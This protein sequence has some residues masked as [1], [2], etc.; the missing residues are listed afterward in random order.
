MDERT[1]S[2]L[3]A[4]DAP[5]V[6]PGPSGVA[7]RTRIKGMSQRDEE[8]LWEA[9]TLLGRLAA[10][11][12]KA[13]CRYGTGHDKHA[14]A[15]RKRALT[16]LSS[17]RWAG[18]I[19]KASNDQWALSRRN[20]AAFIAERRAAVAT[21]SH[22]LSLPVGEPG[23]KDKPGGYRSKHEYFVKSRRLGMLEGQLAQAQ[24]D[25]DAGRVHVCR[26]GRR[27][28]NNRHH[29]LDDL[30][31]PDTPGLSPEELTAE[32]GH[33]VGQWRTRWNAKRLFLHAD[34][35]TG[36]RWGNLTIRLTPEGEVSLKLPAA[37]AHRANAPHG[38]Y[39]LDGR[40]TF[41][42]RGAEW[43]DR[44]HADRAVA[45]TI[46]YDADRDRWYITAAWQ[47]APAPILPLQAALVAGCVGVDTND[48]HLA[49][50]RLD[51]H[52]NPVGDP[53]RF[54][55]D[56]SGSSAHRDAQ[57]R[58][59]LTRLLHWARREGVKAIAIEDLDFADEKTREKH[60]RRKRFRNLISRFPTARLRARLT[61]MAAEAGIQVVA[62]DAAYTSKWGAQH[63]RKPLTT[64]ER[65]VTRHDAASIAIGRRALGHKI[66]RRT[67]PPPRHQSDAAGHRTVQARAHAQACGDG[68]P[69]REGTRPPEPGPRT[70][71]VKPKPMPPIGPPA[72][73]TT[74]P[75]GAS[76]GVA[77]RKAGDQRAQDRSGHAG[78]HGSWVQDP[79]PLT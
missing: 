67:A 13:R 68:V 52:G 40:A 49:A 28:L 57:I 14:W 56:L 37:L 55:Y 65:Q 29:L 23:T 74:G 77:G 5:F 36:K 18:S 54:C 61:S 6:A 20:Q 10:A 24:A 21:I 63:W 47:P 70:R 71:C 39:V 16:V 30:T 78:E 27:L 17:A 26:G 12:L 15:E 43:A 19:T 53:K 9:G 79:L 76:G 72:G 35:E 60:G 46:N 51:V 1:A 62:V 11:D 75:P 4:I 66:R 25:D 58:H 8:I 45:Y 7:I 69:G 64:K 44:V 34:G 59:A 41:T 42:Y 33:R 48:D 73:P 32:A 2:G 3:R 50:W 22:R 38:W 31:G